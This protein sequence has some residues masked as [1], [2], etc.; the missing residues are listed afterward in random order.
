M[1]YRIFMDCNFSK[2]D[3]INIFLK[4]LF[5]RH[6]NPN[7]EHPNDIYRSSDIHVLAFIT[8]SLFPNSI[9][10]DFPNIEYF[11]T[12]SNLQSRNTNW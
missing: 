6:E 11:S 4:C 3:L 9:F 1:G 8:N 2:M 5:F 10:D 7:F 12:E